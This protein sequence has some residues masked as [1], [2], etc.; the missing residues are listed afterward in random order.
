MWCNMTQ[1]LLTVKSIGNVDPTR[2]RVS[3]FWDINALRTLGR[4]QKHRASRFVN[5]T[6]CASIEYYMIMLNRIIVLAS[7]NPYCPPRPRHL[8][9][10][11]L[12]HRDPD[13]NALE[14]YALKC[15]T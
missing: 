14:L 9:G 6:L 15:V 7:C 11:C 2:F 5:E 10:M 3:V 4:D 8:F 13:E 12:I 1:S